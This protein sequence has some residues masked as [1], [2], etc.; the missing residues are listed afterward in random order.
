MTRSPMSLGALFAKLHEEGLAASPDV[1]AVA[2]PRDQT[3]WFMRIVLGFTG[4]I[5]GFLLMAAVGGAFAMLFREGTMLPYVGIAFCIAAALIYRAG[6]GEIIQQLALAIS[7]AGQSMFAFGLLSH[8]KDFSPEIAWPLAIFQVVLVVVMRNFLHRFLSTLFAAAALHWGL[9]KLGGLGIGGGAIAVA[10]A[11]MWLQEARWRSHPSAEAWSAAAIALG[12]ALTAWSA[13]LLV[14]RA[15]DAHL[16][17]P[18]YE[19]LGYDAG[20]LVYTWGVTR[21]RDMRD[22]ALALFASLL[23]AAACHRAP[24]VIACTLVLLAAFGAGQRVLAGW[25]ILAL[26]G[27]L[28]YFYYQLDQTLLVKA[29]TLA[30]AGATL[31]VMRFVFLRLYREE[32]LRRGEAHG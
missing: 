1:P 26:F 5:A 11:L 21:G 8:A 18:P 24:G 6:K 7:M 15:F 17:I 3:P 27:Y 22:R 30:T 10:F 32:N 16:S 2:D 20:L 19:S 28:G 31:L 9:Y 29:A 12:V 4:W 14:L 13:P 25:A 23:L